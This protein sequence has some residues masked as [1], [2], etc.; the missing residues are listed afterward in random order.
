[1]DAFAQKVLFVG[2]AK[3]RFSGASNQSLASGMKAGL[4]GR[5]R[6]PKTTELGNSAG[7]VDNTVNG[8]FRCDYLGEVA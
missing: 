1:L 8:S 4:L 5:L 7:C 2:S 3:M 6:I